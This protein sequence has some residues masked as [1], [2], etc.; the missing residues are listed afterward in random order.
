MLRVFTGYCPNPTSGPLSVYAQ[1]RRYLASHHDERCPR[2]AFIQD[3]CKEIHRA[4]EEGNHIILLIDGNSNMK[5]SKLQKTWKY[6]ICPRS[7][8]RGM[9]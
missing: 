7:F 4:S 2:E 9:E 3:I 1:H 8:Y 5:D 6:A